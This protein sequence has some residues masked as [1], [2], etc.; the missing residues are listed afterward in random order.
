MSD[1]E[2]KN[3]KL[4]REFEFKNFREAFAFMTQVALIAEKHDHHPDWKNSYNKVFITLTNHSEGGKV[5][6]K[7]REMAKAIDKLL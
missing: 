2:E 1:W 4:I 6:E 5:T 3:D 7:D